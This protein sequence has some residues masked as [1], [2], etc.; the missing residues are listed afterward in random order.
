MNDR[1]P[2]YRSSTYSYADRLAIRAQI[3]TTPFV[4]VPQIASQ[5]GL[6]VDQVLTLAADVIERRRRGL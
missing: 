2:Y 6:S 5:W 3:A 4:H 1:P